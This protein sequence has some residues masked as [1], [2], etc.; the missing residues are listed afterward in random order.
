MI[1]RFEWLKA[2]LQSEVLDRAKVMATALAVQFGNDE[3]GQLN[4]ALS[5]LCDYLRMS[6]DTA[7]RAIAD[8]EKAGW[9]TKST[10]LGRGNRSV[11]VLLSPGHV[12][13]LRPHSAQSKSVGKVAPVAAKRSHGCGGSRGGKGRT[14]AAKRSHGC[15]PLY[16]DEQSFE[17]RKGTRPTPHLRAAVILGS[18]QAKEWDDWLKRHHQPALADLKRLQIDDGHCLTTSRP[19]ISSDAIATRV[20]MNLIEWAKDQEESH[21]S[22]A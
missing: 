4:P 10:G 22:A 16:K 9:L 6:E 19:P 7:R 1:N 5:T 20:A 8:L 12:V 17:Q 2:V 14:G 18:E 21:A 13:P 3:T 11:Y 15:N